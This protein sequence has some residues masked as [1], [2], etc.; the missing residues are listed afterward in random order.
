MV[1]GPMYSL[2]LGRDSEV[3]EWENANVFKRQG[4]DELQWGRDWEVAECWRF[5]MF[6]NDCIAVL[7][8]GRDCQVAEYEV[9]E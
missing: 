6:G 1:G 5:A 2:Q 8:W 9:A 7:R 4:G 3:A